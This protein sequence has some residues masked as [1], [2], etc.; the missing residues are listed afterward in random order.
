L[1]DQ[2]QVTAGPHLGVHAQELEINCDVTPVILLS[3]GIEADGPVIATDG[4]GAGSDKLT[5]PHA[6]VLAVIKDLKDKHAL[7]CLRCAR[8]HCRRHRHVDR[9]RTVG[10]AMSNKAGVE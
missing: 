8:T 4:E 5:G 3:A 2:P 6:P 7:I 10:T 9:C 1:V